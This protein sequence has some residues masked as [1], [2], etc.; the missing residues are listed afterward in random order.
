MHDALPE[1]V[2]GNKSTA[3]ALHPLS[4]VGDSSSESDGSVDWAEEGGN[5]GITHKQQYIKA[6]AGS[7]GGAGTSHA[8]IYKFTDSA[9]AVMQV[10]MTQHRLYAD[11]DPALRDVCLWEFAAVM[12]LEVKRKE[13][14]DDAAAPVRSRSA[15]FKLSSDNPLH[16]HFELVLRCKFSVPIWT[17]RPPQA[18][19]EWTGGGAPPDEWHVQA[20]K[21]AEQILTVFCPWSTKEDA[22]ADH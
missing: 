12:G 21:F 8:P 9:G 20:T 3:A 1:A 5:D 11:R 16:D 22:A 13:S 6:F 19:K 10:P 2:S 17:K 7:E 4:S 15:R 18:P 14:R